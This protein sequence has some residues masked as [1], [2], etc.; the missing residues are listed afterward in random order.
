MRLVFEGLF[1][2]CEVMSTYYRYA[3]RPEADLGQR[4]I[5]YIRH[6]HESLQDSQSHTLVAA[7]FYYFP[8]RVGNSDSG[9]RAESPADAVL[10]LLI[11]PKV[12]FY[13]IE[14][15]TKTEIIRIAMSC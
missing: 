8:F 7:K 2:S 1:G 14:Y 3:K 15:Q 6:A 9:F 4:F 10:Y 12:S 13:Y 5:L 11:Q